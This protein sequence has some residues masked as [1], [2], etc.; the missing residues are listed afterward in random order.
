MTVE[1]FTGMNCGYCDRAKALLRDREIPFTE[2]DI[3][4]DA[5]NRD[6]LIRRLPRSKSIPQ[7][8]V[9]GEHIGGYEDLC[10]L[11]ENGRLAELVR[12]GG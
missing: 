5:A 1:I 4:G 8:F 6:E 9:D 10:H 2:L 3:S 12:P 7:V 11:D